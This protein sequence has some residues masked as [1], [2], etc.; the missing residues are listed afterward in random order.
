VGLGKRAGTSGFPMINW[1]SKLVIMKAHVFALFFCLA[2][3]QLAVA[4]SAAPAIPDLP[5]DAVIAVL[6][7]GSKMTMGDFRAIV[8][9]QPPE[10][11][12]LAKMNSKRFILW[13][14]GLRKFTRMAEEEKL[15]QRPDIKAQLEYA[16]TA[17]LAQAEMNAKL[18]GIMPSNEEISKFYEDHKERYLQVKVK[19]IYIAYG[20]AVPSGKKAMTE[21]QAKT[22]AESLL[23]QIRKGADFVKLARENSDDETSR[24]KDADFATFKPKDNIPDAIRTAVLSLKEGDVTE[25]VQQANG[26]YLLKASEVSFTPLDQV[27][28]DLILEIRQQQ[29][30][31]WQRKHSDNLRVEYPNKAFPP[32]EPTPAAR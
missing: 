14:A 31:E 8:A 17:I 23:A 24:D 19:A 12:Q 9:A 22:K 6:D 32:D 10:T 27:R 18:N 29:Y 11:Q 30:S 21:S 7:D 26:Y 16:H 15:D 4:Q 2:G 3:A 5:D 25:P 13:W 28:G 20:D 1:H